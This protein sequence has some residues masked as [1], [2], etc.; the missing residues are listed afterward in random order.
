VI[1]KAATLVGGSIT[2]QAV[3]DALA[4]FGKGS[5]PAYQ[6]ISGRILFDS[7]GN[8]IDK[9]IVVLQVQSSSNGDQIVLLRIAGTFF[10]K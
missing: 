1:I 2:G 6:G 8:P 10:T 5:V 9:A 7:Q 4:S 3:R